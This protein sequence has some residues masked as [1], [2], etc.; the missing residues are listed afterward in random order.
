M[1]ARFS[2]KECIVV[3]VC[4]LPWAA[5]LYFVHINNHIP[6][7]PLQQAL[8]S[9]NF[10]QAKRLIQEGRIADYNPRSDWFRTPLMMAV[11][12]SLWGY[13]HEGHPV[14]WI[15]VVNLLLT[16]DADVNET[17]WLCYTP[18]HQ[19]ASGKDPKIIKILLSHGATL[20]RKN[21]HGQTPL[22]IAA[23]V[24]NVPVIN[25]LLIAG[26]NPR[27]LAKDGKTALEYA[28]TTE[29]ATLIAEAKN[30]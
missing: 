17:G 9:K 5:G 1:S 19:A 12:N 29:I 30:K 14:D 25:E 23:A 27:S 11:H 26:A 16:S 2:L 7:S 8:D 28:K 21:C 10:E 6:L 15:E 4:F 3:L 18:L 20:D 24:G 13:D 22:M